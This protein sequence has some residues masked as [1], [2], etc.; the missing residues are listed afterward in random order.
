ML[1]PLL[2]KVERWLSISLKRSVYI[3]HTSGITSTTSGTK[4]YYEML[5]GTTSDTTRT[6][7][8]YETV[9]VNTSGTTRY[10]EVL[11]VTMR[12]YEWY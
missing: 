3:R 7:R 8:Y 10:N 11:R 4:R 1:L 5:R 9:R 12:Y 6:T 2:F